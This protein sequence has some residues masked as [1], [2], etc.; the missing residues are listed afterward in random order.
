MQSACSFLFRFILIYTIGTT[1]SE[2]D[3][4]AT[5]QMI[6]GALQKFTKRLYKRL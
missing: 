1:G 2:V 4:Y 3:Q 5:L 6:R